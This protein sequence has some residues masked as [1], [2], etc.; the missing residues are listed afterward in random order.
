MAT[1]RR[2]S[3]RSPQL[4][5][6]CRSVQTPKSVR[7]QRSS[8]RV[9]ETENLTSVGSKVPGLVVVSQT[10]DIIKPCT[11]WPYVQLA[12]LQKVENSFFKEV[13]KG[14]RPTFA[15]LPAIEAEHLVA[16]F[17]LLMTVEKSVLADIPKSSVV[18]GVRNNAKARAFAEG[19]SRKFSRFAFPDDFV[20]AVREIQ[21]RLKQ[22]HG[23]DSP[24]GD[25]YRVLREIRVVATPK[26]EAPQ[27]I[28]EFLLSGTKTAQ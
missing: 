5:I 3:R 6:R 9:R 26:W 20:A 21:A 16:N 15:S 17:E 28:I 7:A 22:K 1:R 11:E 19:I 2:H 24:E 12:A 25:A 10:C 13:R 23:K 27:P 14:L 4:Y 18:H 8:D